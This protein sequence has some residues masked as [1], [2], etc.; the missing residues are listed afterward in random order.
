MNL[1]RGLMMEEKK[2]KKY[3]KPEL[4]KIYLDAE[5]AVLGACKFSGGSGP[6]GSNCGLPFPACNQSSS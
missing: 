5:C 4:T 2:K 3:V 1:M 6:N